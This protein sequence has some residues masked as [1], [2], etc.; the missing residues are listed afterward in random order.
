MAF[1]RLRDFM[2]LLISTKFEKASDILK[3]R[4]SNGILNINQLNW[5]T[6]KA[7]P[8]SLI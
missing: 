3:T 6:L 5:N 2:E 8:D 4:F 7:H 1:I